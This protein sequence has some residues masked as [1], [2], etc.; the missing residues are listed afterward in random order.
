METD[1]K[2]V[3]VIFE[4]QSAYDVLHS[5][6]DQLGVRSVRDAL[7][8]I[9][10]ENVIEDAAFGTRPIKPPET[11][12]EIKFF[13]YLEFSPVP[14]HYM[15]DIQDPIPFE[16]AVERPIDMRAELWAI[17]RELVQAGLKP[18]EFPSFSACVA[19]LRRRAEA[20][21]G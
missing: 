5:L 10:A 6:C 20:K 12:E 11:G 16:E 13:S 4:Q 19:E 21:N 7:I 9:H 3:V 2:D 18:W 8:Q 15:D 14:S 1:L 17:N